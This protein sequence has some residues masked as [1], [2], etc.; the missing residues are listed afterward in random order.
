MF[1]VIFV[2]TIL[3]F[4]TLAFSIDCDEYYIDASQVPFGSSNDG[5]KENPWGAITEAISC[6]NPSEENIVILHLA[7]GRYDKRGGE[8]FP[9][10]PKSHIVLS[11]SGIDLTIIDGQGFEASVIY[12]KGQTDVTIENLTITGGMGERGTWG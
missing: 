1:R 12:C 5:S 3:F 9:L 4:T 6:V 7:P 2:M 11:G 8:T 10:S